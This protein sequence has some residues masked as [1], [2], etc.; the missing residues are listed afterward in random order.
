[1]PAMH[2]LALC[3][4]LLAG[5][6]G[7]PQLPEGPEACRSVTL[8]EVVEVIDG[9]T[10]DVTFLEGDLY[11]TTDRVRFNGIDTPEVNHA[12]PLDSEYCGLRAW[13]EAVSLLEG[14]EVWLTFD[15]SC[16]GTF[17][18]TLV[19]AF[20]TSDELWF[21][22]H[23]VEQGYARVS[24]FEFSFEDLFAEKEAEAMSAGR[25]LWGPCTE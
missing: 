8:A 15:T 5:C 21:N 22:E 17:G 6:S 13:N 14:E 12:D 7:T 23:M 2:R 1:M 10:A 25:G 9:D 20:R 3:A 18:R 19:Y 11:G 4:S 16:T 24:G